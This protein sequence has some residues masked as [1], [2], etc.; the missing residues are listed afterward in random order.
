MK[1]L[2][3]FIPNVGHENLRNVEM[4]IEIYIKVTLDAKERNFVANFW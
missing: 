1:L 4:M 3:I 2:E